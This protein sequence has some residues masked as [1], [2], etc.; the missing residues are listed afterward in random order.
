MI[1]PFVY[2]GRD[3]ATPV[4]LITSGAYSRFFNKLTQTQKHW[5][6]QNGFSG[7][8]GQLL[9]LP[10][11][12]GSIERL[13]FGVC[14]LDN[15]F[16]IA[17]LPLKLPPGVYSLEGTGVKSRLESLAIG[18][19]LGCYQFDKYKNQKPIDAKLKLPNSANHPRIQGM[20][21]ACSRVRDL[22]NTP[23]EDMMPQH[24][25]AVVAELA[26]TYAADFEEIVG[27]DLMAENY[28]CIYT[29]GRASV[30]AP[31][32][33]ELNWGEDSHPQ[34][35]LVGKGICFDSGGLDIKPAAGMRTMKKDMGG[36]AQ[37]IGLAQLIM[38]LE[39]PIRL[40][41]L[42]PAAENAI[43]S[44]SYRPGDVL[45]TRSGL[46][47]EIDN[48]DAEGRLVLCDAL[49]EAC[50]SKPD[51]VIDFATLT[52]AAR[53][54]V[55]TEIAAFFCNNREL[56]EEVRVAGESVDDPTWELP[57][58]KGYKS[59]LDSYVAD[60]LNSAAT[61][62]GGATTAALYL[63]NFVD[64]EISWVHFDIMAWN[65][66]KRAGRPIGG[67]AMG[68]RAMYDVLEKRFTS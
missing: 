52:G 64:R 5:V 55:G 42:I 22:I 27:D 58:H 17:D 29:V 7:K 8:S 24:L 35:T 36:A 28:P 38:A 53:V 44:N 66:R 56:A 3:P 57:L 23:A 43:S 63:Q 11:T 39:L 21:A 9:A 1:E 50:E 19:G 49:V 31:R 25:S 12:D 67:E 40:R 26:Q 14:N 13:V 45:K 4:T 54:A 34:V 48:T 15:Y 46:T 30:N 37:V 60:T 33:I 65:S 18:W 2:G 6:E 47:V 59:L 51:L 61:P 41:V 62:F 68:V 20:V 16:A 10:S 32:L